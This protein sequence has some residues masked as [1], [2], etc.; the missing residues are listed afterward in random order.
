MKRSSRRIVNL[1]SKSLTPA[2]QRSIRSLK[3]A[4]CTAIASSL[5]ASSLQ[6]TA[7]ES[8][9]NNVTGNWSTAGNWTPAAAPTSSTGTSL[10][11]GGTTAYT[12]TNDIGGATATFQANA[13]LFNNTSAT[14]GVTIGLAG[15]RTIT[16]ASASIP[17]T[18]T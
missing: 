11:F 8:T 10:I 1:N 5:L 17:P 6:A 18:P 9:W 3:W 4:A 7:A 13:L 2:G 14:G 16:L 12:A 15:T